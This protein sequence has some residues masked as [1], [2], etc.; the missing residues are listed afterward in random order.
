ML[1]MEPRNVP[2]G[3]LSLDRGAEVAEQ[4]VNAGQTLVDNLTGTGERTAADSTLAL[5][6]PGG[7]GTEGGVVSSGYVSS[8]AVEWLVATSEEELDQMLESSECYATLTVPAGFSEHLVATEAREQLGS[9]LVKK[10]PEL[11]QGACS[12]RWEF[13]SVGLSSARWP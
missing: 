13:K 4:Q 7:E 6:I 11:G 9:A 8:D 5:A 10:L 3:I 1:K 2:V 12:V